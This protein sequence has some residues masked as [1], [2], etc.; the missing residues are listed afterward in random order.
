MDGA[1]DWRML[2]SVLF[3]LV[4]PGLISTSDL[5]VHRGLERIHHGVH[6]HEGRDDVHAAGL[7]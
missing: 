2:W 4:A 1:S 7:A 6:V 5:R 3:P